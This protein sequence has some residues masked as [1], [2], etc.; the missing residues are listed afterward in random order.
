MD[1]GERDR[2]RNAIAA[3]E[4]GERPS[5]TAPESD[6][7]FSAL[8]GELDA[9]P[10]REAITR[11]LGSSQGHEELRLFLALEQ[12]LG[13]EA[14]V[15]APS[16]VRRLV[17]VVGTLAAAAAALVWILRPAPTPPEAG[18]IRAPAEAAMRSALDGESLPR[19]A[20][21]LRWESAGEACTYDLR[22]ST[23]QGVLLT[24]TF[25]LLEPSLT[26]EVESLPTA[27]KILWQVDFV[28]E[29]R[30]GQSNTFSTS[31]VP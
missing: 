21:E 10:S 30:R 16:R 17:F 20:F 27:G 6:V 26:L 25:G 2:W 7:L 9:V 29:E 18:T 14:P 24:E 28:C 31:V 15:P 11:A 19:D 5:Q 8:Q 3:F 23:A 13:L 22:A 1:S 4:D 12:E